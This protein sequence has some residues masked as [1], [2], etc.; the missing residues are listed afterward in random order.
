MISQFHRIKEIKEIIAENNK[1]VIRVDWSENANLFQ[2]RKEKGSY[3]HN[4]QVSVNAIVT[5]QSSGVSSHGT[6]SDAK[7]HKALAVWASLEKVLESF[8]L[9]QLKYLYVISDSPTSQYRNKYNAFFTKRFAVENNIRV[10]WVFTESGHGNG[11]M[12][13]VGA[14]I[15]NDID[16]AF[17]FHPNSVISCVS[18]LMPLISVAD[19]HLSVFIEEDIKS[20]QGLLPSD[21][22]IVKSRKS[23][24]ISSIHEIRFTLENTNQIEWMA[25]SADVAFI[26]VQFKSKSLRNGPLVSSISGENTDDL[27][28]DIC[29]LFLK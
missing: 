1:S 24:G 28:K 14:S 10:Y 29:I 7:S 17:A 12:D 16:D 25:I 13:G 22:D 19:K 18:D 4:I 21:L 26:S 2:A 23:I 6:I 20:H 11:P 5:Y 3:Y 8:N 9:E 15:K 27:E